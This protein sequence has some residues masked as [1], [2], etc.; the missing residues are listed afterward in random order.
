MISKND[1]CIGFEDSE[2][3]AFE[4][5]KRDLNV[6]KHFEYEV[7]DLDKDIFIPV[8]VY[9]SDL[10]KEARWAKQKKKQS[11][12][13]PKRNDI[14]DNKYS[15]WLGTQPC[16]ITRQVAERGIGAY[17]IHCH[18]I[19]GRSGGRNDYMQVPLI[20]HVHSWGSKSY[21]SCAKS[22]FIKHHNLEVT[23][24]I[25]FFKGHA[26]SLRIAYEK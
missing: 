1:K 7:K 5:I 12:S 14:I 8:D 16:V 26:K 23:D 17:D 10:K 24:V 3:E 20:G 6:K 15:K 13:K 19:Y 25:E 11:K 2:V 4:L 18:H 21:H 22:D 9:V